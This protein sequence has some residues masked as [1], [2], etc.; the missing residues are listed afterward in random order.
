MEVKEKLKEHMKK[1]IIALIAAETANNASAFT[2]STY[3]SFRNT[4]A[5][6]EALFYDIITAKGFSFIGY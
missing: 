6:S 4:F 2:T 5:A 3:S 1:V